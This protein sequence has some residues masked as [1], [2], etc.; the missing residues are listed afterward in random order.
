MLVK[1]FF[2][3]KPTTVMFDTGAGAT[4]CYQS[5]LDRLGVEPKWTGQAGRVT[6]VGGEVATKLGLITVQAGSM[7]RLLPVW[8]QQDHGRGG[9]NSVSDLPLL[10]QD[11]LKGYAYEIDNRAKQVIMTKSLGN[12]AGASRGRLADNEVPFE[13]EGNHVIVKPK[14]NGRECEMILDT[15]AGI[16]AFA[17]RHLAMCGLNTPTSARQGGASGVG[18]KRQ[19][20]NFYIDS[21]KLGPIE[22]RHVPAVVMMH[23]N[24]PKPLLGQPFLHDIKYEIDPVRKVIKFK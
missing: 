13:R 15:G 5:L 7:T 20:Y 22:K 3:G 16:V 14:I 17:D 1:A 21:I 2:N 8:V 11:F 4:T 12:P 9:K 19:G 6:G 24:F 23:S 10:G 18:G